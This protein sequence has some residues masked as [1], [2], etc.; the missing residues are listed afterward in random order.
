V[1]LQPDACVIRDLTPRGFWLV[2]RLRRTPEHQRRALVDEPAG[3]ITSGV[4]PAPI[5]AT[6]DVSEI[7]QAVASAASGERSEKVLSSA[8]GELTPKRA[9][10][11]SRSLPPMPGR[12]R[13]GSRPARRGAPPIR[14]TLDAR[15]RWSLVA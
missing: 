4:P 12:A 7:K 13:T 8:D 14:Q 10:T 9:L 11:S 2:N 5:H 1:R 15:V 6:L 3:L